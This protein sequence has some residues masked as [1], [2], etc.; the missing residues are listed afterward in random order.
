M[1]EHYIPDLAARRFED[2]DFEPIL[3][4]KRR[5]LCMDLD[6]TLL[7]QTGFDI[8]QAVLDK[9]D[10]LRTSGK[11]EDMCLISNVIVPG[12]RV[13]RLYQLADKLSIKNVV[14]C[15]F[16]TRK[17]KAAPFNAAL[18]H[19]KAKPEE[20]VMVGDQI[21]SDILG[22]NRLGFYTIWLERMSPDNWTTI[23]VGKRFREKFVIREMRARGL[24]DYQNR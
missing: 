13:G 10:D 3:D 9:L 2:I 1:N 23:A 5:F 8:S 24:L 20:C 21:F 18:A 14:P 22:A 7:P 4:E 11:V 17:P 19:L 12:K 16:F 15:Y 6:N